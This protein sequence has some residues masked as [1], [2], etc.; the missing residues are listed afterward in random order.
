MAESPTSSPDLATIRERDDLLATKVN[1]PRTRPDWLARPRLLQRLNEGMARDLVLVCT[2]A[3]FGKT[4]LLADWATGATWPV[5]WLSLDSQDNDPVRFWRYVIAALDR[6][7]GDLAEHVLPLLTAPPVVSSEGVVTAVIKQLEARPDELALVLDD[8]HV[9]ESAAIHHS[10]AF[11]LRHLPSQ[12]HLII[13]GRSD[14]PLP[15]ARLRAGD[16]LAELRTADLRFTPEES[17][18]FLQEVWNL[19]LPTAAVTA[20]DSRTEGWA[21]GLQLAALS[22]QGRPDPAAFLDAFTGTHRYVLDYLSEE[23]LA[24]QPEHLTRFLLETSILERL[25]GPL[26]DAVTGG[27]DGQAMLE[28]LD[29]ANLFV[30]PLDEERRWYRFHHL[31]G[32]LLRARLQRADARRVPELHRRAADWCEQH[33]LVDEA[34]RH[35]LAS[36]DTLRA[37]RLVEQHMAETLRR[38]E[39]V[40]LERWLAA[41]P[42]Q[43]VESRPGLCMAQG[44]VARE[45]GLVDSVERCLEHAERAFDQEQDPGFQVPTEGGM[46]AQV[47]AAI[48]LLRAELAGGRGDAEGL[49]GHARSALAHM[50]EE[51]PGPRLWARYL[52]ACA[53]W[54]RG[55]LGR[56]EAGFAEVLAEARLTPNTYPRMTACY[57]LGSVQRERGELDAALRTYR[58][59]LTLAAKGGDELALHSGEAHVGIAQVLYERNQ[60]D[61]ALRHV[62]GGIALYRQSNYTH[63]LPHGLVTLAWIHQATGDPAGAL[64]VMDE[65]CQILPGGELN[66]LYNPAPA[67]RVRLLLLQ[68]RQEEVAGWTVDR[69]L[70]EEDE[71][72]YRRQAHHLVLARVLLAQSQPGRAVRLLERLDALAQAEGRTASLIQI[73]ALRSL[74]LQS[75]GDRQSAVSMLAQA[76]SLAQP[77]GF[78]RIFADEGLPMAAVLRR[79]T[80]VRQRGRVAAPSSVA[81]EHLHRVVQAFEPASGGRTEQP[82]NARPAPPGLIEPLTDRE[83]EV[84]RLLA[85]GRRNRDIA[86]ELVVTLETVKKH[87]SHIFAKLGAANRTE[88]VA[89]ARRLGLLS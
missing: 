79:L 28:E 16:Q 77:Q 75:A 5:A 19:D 10:L 69:R 78:I 74:A 87:T 52:L 72:S 27:A 17:A 42:A 88:A 7:G 25:S 70:G 71:L 53:D 59:G 14:P 38:G 9:I 22:L 56:A 23:V 55:R 15:V 49:A 58:E 65:A 50:S 2:P 20:L 37:T 45:R 33:G 68:G 29:R 3:G 48:G 61:E 73:R 83:L 43:V 30:L 11:L 40:I 39:G 46:V 80:G 12:L 13:A 8:Y 85:A 57:T 66:P 21:V 6:L 63:M 84:L 26:C 34:I 1:I 62:T 51:E 67:E 41:L 4:T 18:A 35:A 32:D 81:R 44:L 89:H 54:M 86:Q 47:S 60:L 24:R 76:F 64:A 82:V 36:E 31:F